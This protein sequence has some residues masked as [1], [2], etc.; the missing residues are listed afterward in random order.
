MPA[1]GARAS[2]AFRHVC[3]INIVYFHLDKISGNK[4]LIETFFIFKNFYLLSAKEI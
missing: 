4:R 2:V 1:V 3:Y